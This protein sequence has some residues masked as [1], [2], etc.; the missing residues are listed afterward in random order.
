MHFVHEFCCNFRY[1]SQFWV[2]EISKNK[3]RHKYFSGHP[4]GRPF[5]VARLDFLDGQLAFHV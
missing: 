5:K 3:Q 4:W 1:D 2:T